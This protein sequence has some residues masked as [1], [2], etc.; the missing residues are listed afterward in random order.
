MVNNS[1]VFHENVKKKSMKMDQNK[2]SLKETEYWTTLLKMIRD[3][4]TYF[5]Q[6]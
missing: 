1:E 3:K 4:E 2:T 5:K 6:D